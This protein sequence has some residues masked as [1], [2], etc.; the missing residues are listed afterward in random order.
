MD[1]ILK[2][3]QTA[4]FIMFFCTDMGFYSYSVI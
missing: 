4:S 2:T 1:E 3:I